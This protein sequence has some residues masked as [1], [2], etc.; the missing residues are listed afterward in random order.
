MSNLYLYS[1]IEADEAGSGERKKVNMQIDA[2]CALGYPTKIIVNEK[3]GNS[4]RYRSRLPGPFAYSNEIIKETVDR[5]GEDTQFIYIRKYL[6]DSSFIKLLKQIRQKKTDIRIFMEIPTYP[7]DREW[8]RLI[9]KPMLW[10]E[11]IYRQHVD[12]YL[13]YIITLDDS[14]EIFGVPCIN[15]ING[16]DQSYI[17]TRKPVKHTGTDVH[18]LAVALFQ[19]SHGYE[20]VLEGMHTYYQGNPE[21]KIMFHLV[22]DGVEKMYGELIRKWALEPYLVQYGRLYGEELDKV[23]DYCQIGIGPLGLYKAGINKAGTLKSR[24]Y[25]AR[26]LPFVYSGTDDILEENGFPYACQVSNDR[27]PLDLNDVLEFYD[28]L[29]DE[30]EMIRRM[31]QFSEDHFQWKSIMKKVVGKL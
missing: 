10:K 12:R 5:I 7:Y 3:H 25:C 6:I 20:R 16:I 23:F 11:K 18:M 14:K 30:E 31:A 26:G 4:F 29:G 21:R 28:R 8:F 22:G 13:D 2:L 24:E 9:D 1:T 19:P 27:T 17:R 15:I